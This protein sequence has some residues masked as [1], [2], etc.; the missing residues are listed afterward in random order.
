MKISIVTDEISSDV[1]T[2]IELGL[3]WGVRDFELRGIGFRVCPPT[4]VST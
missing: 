1:E 3:E 4:R 2:A